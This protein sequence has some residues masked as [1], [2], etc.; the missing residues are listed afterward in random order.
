M[1]PRTD[2]LVLVD[3]KEVLVFY[4]NFHIFIEGNGFIYLMPMYKQNPIFT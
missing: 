2:G 3:A 1:S 4:E